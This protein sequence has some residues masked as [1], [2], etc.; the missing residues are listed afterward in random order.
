MR[1]R[2][3]RANRDATPF[4]L[5]DKHS[6]EACWKCVERCHKRVIGKINLFVHKHAKLKNPEECTG[7][8]KCVKTCPNGAFTP[9][10]QSPRTVSGSGES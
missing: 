5:F 4:V 7:C 9:I 1:A 2:P 8:L 6:C 10:V 3:T